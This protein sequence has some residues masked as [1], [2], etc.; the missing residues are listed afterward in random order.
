MIS[1]I[2]GKIYNELLL[3]LY[4]ELNVHTWQVFMDYIM[5]LVNNILWILLMKEIKGFDFVG[6]CLLNESNISLTQILR[7][8]SYGLKQ[9]KIKESI[10]TRRLKQVKNNYL[11]DKRSENLRNNLSCTYKLQRAYIKGYC[12]NNL[13]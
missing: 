10:N 12:D 11:S 9:A 6:S 2:K 3:I 13:S 7:L 5:T 8:L 4:H 1:S